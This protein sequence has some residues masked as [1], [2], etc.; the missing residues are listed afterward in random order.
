LPST[1]RRAR[2]NGDAIAPVVPPESRK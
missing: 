2:G 1:Q